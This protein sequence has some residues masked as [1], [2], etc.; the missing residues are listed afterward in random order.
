MMSTHFSICCGVRHQKT[1][2]LAIPRLRPWACDKSHK[3]GFSVAAEIDFRFWALQPNLLTREQKT[4]GPTD[5]HFGVPSSG[6]LS[7]PTV[8]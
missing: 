2:T 3:P 6:H 1:L 7:S 5:R 4:W 8:I